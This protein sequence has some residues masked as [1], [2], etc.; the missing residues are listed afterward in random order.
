MFFLYQIG[1]HISTVFIRVVAIFNHKV[2]QFVKGRKGLFEE[3]Q[4]SLDPVKPVI[5]MH[6][7]SLGEYEQGL[8]V[9]TQLKKDFPRHQILL[10]FFSPSGYEIK[11]DK[12]VADKVSYLP[13]DT[14]TNAQRFL[15]VV[16][17]QIALFVKY[18]VWPNFFK[19]MQSRDIPFFLISA[20]FKPEQ[21]YFRW[22]GGMMKKAL[23]RVNHFFVQD[24]KSVSLLAKIGID[25]TTLSGDTRFDRVSTIVRQDNELL[26]M[27]RFKEG[28]FCIVAGSTWP[29]DEDP[30][31]KYINQ[32]SDSMKFVMVPHN[33]DTDSCD[34]LVKRIRKK[35]IR[36]S[37][38]ILEEVEDYQVLIIDKIGLL[39]KIYSYA[40]LAYVGG[41]YATGLHNT[42]E[43]AVFGIPII[44]GPKYQGFKEAK[45]LVALNGIIPTKGF[46][47]LKNWIDQYYSNGEL[48]Q[49]AGSINESYVKK[50]QGASIRIME[51]LRTLL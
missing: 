6:T 31:I 42:L 51:H 23:Q 32:A 18:E 48:R 44:I 38:M 47:D 3:L 27:R 13:L 21:I 16:K 9:L 35:A 45:D 25:R 50:N 4:N 46:E 43:P 34:D 28:K 40:D 11:K 30:I 26:F 20:R 24:E 37:K 39:T 12:S 49:R 15:E 8:P 14:P 33:I 29:Q 7:A 36:Y 5:W 17:P 19:A 10:T 1:I 22:Y 41:G 2:R